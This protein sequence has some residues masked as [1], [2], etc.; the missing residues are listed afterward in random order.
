MSLY[1][2][3]GGILFFPAVGIA[4]H[5]GAAAAADLRNAQLQDLFPRL[6]T[7]P[8]G[9]DDAGIGHEGGSPRSSQNLVGYPLS[10]ASTI[11]SPRTRGTL[12]VGT[13][14][15]DRLQVLGVH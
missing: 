15:V 13:H 3:L 5:T 6:L 11:S 14:A 8:G 9:N 1:L 4:A 7:F 2:K 10:K 12:M